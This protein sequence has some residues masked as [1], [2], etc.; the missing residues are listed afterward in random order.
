M[1]D[2]LVVLKDGTRVKVRAAYCA[3]GMGG[4]G[5]TDLNDTDFI[6]SDERLVAA[7]APG[8]VAYYFDAASCTVIVDGPP[9]VTVPGQPP[10]GWEPPVEMIF[11][12]TGP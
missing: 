2:W 6:D 5:D 12:E 4:D 7:F 9:A 3:S 10:K 11:E 1:R 8:T